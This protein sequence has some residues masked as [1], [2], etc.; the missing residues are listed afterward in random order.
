ML[1]RTRCR[2]SA[3]TGRRPAIARRRRAG[4]AAVRRRR[5]A[6]GRRSPGMPVASRSAPELTRHR[7]GRVRVVQRVRV[8]HRVRVVQR[9]RC[10]ATGSRRASDWRRAS[11]R[12]DRRHDDVVEADALDG[13]DPELRPGLL[14]QRP[15]VGGDG[16]PVGGDDRGEPARTP[17]LRFAVRGSSSSG[18]TSHPSGSATARRTSSA[19]VEV[20]RLRDRAA[21]G[22]RTPWAA[23]TTPVTVIAVAGSST[24]PCD[25]GDRRSAAAGRGSRSRGLR[26]GRRRALRLL[27]VCPRSASDL[28]GGGGEGGRGGVVGLEPQPQHPDR[29]VGELE[30]TRVAHHGVVRWSARRR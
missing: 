18:T 9:V 10:R 11:G 13:V 2:G 24:R 4:A 27:G 20:D 22:R 28:E 12:V 3:T 21:A 19:A 15:A 23:G 14:Q 1:R 6:G 7:V 29:Q 8:V 30:A 5:P 25:R 17:N 26:A 16:G